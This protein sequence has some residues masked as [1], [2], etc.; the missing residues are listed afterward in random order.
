[1][2]PPPSLLSRRPPAERPEL[3]AAR[4]HPGDDAGRGGDGHHQHV[5]VGHVGQLVG[6]HT[7]ELLGVQRLQDAGRHAHHGPLGRA[8]GG[9]GVGQLGVG[10]RDARL[11]HVGHGAQPVDHAV[12]LG[13]L[14]GGHLARTHGPHGRLV[15]EPPLEEGD[16]DADDTHEEGKAGVAAAAEDTS[17]PRSPRRTGHRA[18]TY[19]GHPE[20]ESGVGDEAGAGHVC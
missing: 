16:A 3:R 15:G 12:Q 10:D 11:G 18:G 13:S 9:E 6:E 5:A 7:L 14:L 17:A 20:G 1:M 19:R 4:D 8:A 2:A